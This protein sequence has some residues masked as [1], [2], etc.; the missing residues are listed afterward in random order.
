VRAQLARPG[1][2]GGLEVEV[3]MFR[4]PMAS[5]FGTLATRTVPL[6]I[7]F[8]RE[9]TWELSI[10]LPAGRRAKL[11]SKSGAWKA[12]AE[13]GEYTRSVELS[14]DQ[15]TISSALKTPAQRVT[16]KEYAAFR[17]WAIEVEQSS[18]LAFV[19]E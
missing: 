11:V 15:L 18:Y 1:A 5:Q 4:E 16:P 14:A 2:N 17:K 9:R 12:N 7:G 3:A 13:F 19:V 6:L 10:K 8:G